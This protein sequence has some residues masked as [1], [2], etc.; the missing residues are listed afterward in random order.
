VSGAYKKKK[1]AESKRYNG[2]IFNSNATAA[3]FAALK[4]A[5]VSVWSDAPPPPQSH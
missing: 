5:V 3:L 2:G 4:L 1:E